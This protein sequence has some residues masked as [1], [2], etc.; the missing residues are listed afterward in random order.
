MHDII[1]SN[2][3]NQKVQKGVLLD[4][5]IYVNIFRFLI[6]SSRKIGISSEKSKNRTF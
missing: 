4:E 1:I 3:S 6:D 5:Q 2:Q